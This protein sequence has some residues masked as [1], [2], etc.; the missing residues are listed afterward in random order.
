MDR[1]REEE[2][3]DVVIRDGPCSSA[4]MYQPVASAILTSDRTATQQVLIIANDIPNVL[5]HRERCSVS[6]IV[7]PWASDTPYGIHSTGGKQLR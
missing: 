4:L 3:K 7:Y 5:E 1:R 6:N 2:E